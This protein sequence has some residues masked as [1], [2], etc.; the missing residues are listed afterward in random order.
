MNELKEKRENPTDEFVRGIDIHELLPQREPFVMV[1]RLE[2]F[3]MRRVL[4]S[5]IIV[6]DNLFVENGFFSSFGLIENMAQTCAARI[7]YINKY[8]L[9]KGIQ[10]GFIGA[11]RNFKVNALPAV[12]D[13]IITEV[14]IVE[15][16]FG[17]VLANAVVKREGEILAVTEIKIAIKD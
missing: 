9:L 16:V 3:D 10:I 1:S 7:G 5:T 2:H 15:E 4:A 11:L 12:G 8:V 13:R 6:E 17:M 14:E